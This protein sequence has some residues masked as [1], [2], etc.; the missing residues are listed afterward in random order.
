MFILKPS[1]ADSQY[2]TEEYNIIIKND[3][4][5]FYKHCEQ[6]NKE[7]SWCPIMSCCEVCASQ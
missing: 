3:I 2:Q 4:E 5:Y 1:Q 7:T 6:C